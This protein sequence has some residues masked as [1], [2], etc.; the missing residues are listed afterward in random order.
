MAEIP[1][2]LF[3]QLYRRAPSDSDRQRLIAVKSA[4][5][6]GDRDELWPIIM[7]LDHYSR[8]TNAARN[9]IITAVQG[10]PDIIKGASLEA[11]A[12]AGKAASRAVALAVDGA[13]DR[14]AK[15]AVAKS[16][17]RADRISKKQ[18]IVTM[19]AGGIVAALIA[20]AGAAASYFVLD[21]RGICAEPP[22]VSKSGELA[23]FVEPISG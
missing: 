12:L 22:Q 16:E 13:A 8:S 7:T 2:T 17:T 14:I 11:E 5:G 15:V 3:E 9:E 10:L 18:F 6:I 23:C 4:L 21:A 1:E 20:I 19:V